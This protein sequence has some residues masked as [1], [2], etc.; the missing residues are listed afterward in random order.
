MYRD[1]R[2]VG[3]GFRDDNKVVVGFSKLEFK[4]DW[5]LWFKEVQ[6]GFEQ[7]GI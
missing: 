5:G 2:K 6:V 7:T 3:G 4:I 1:D